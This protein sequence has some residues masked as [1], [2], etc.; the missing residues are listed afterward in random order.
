[1][2]SK[3]VGMAYDGKEYEEVKC[4]TACEGE[5]PTCGPRISDDGPLHEFQGSD[6]I[7]GSE[8]GAEGSTG[9]P[10]LVAD[11]DTNQVPMGCDGA[12]IATSLF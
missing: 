7:R 5:G 8:A 12:L 2:C 3:E 10:P 6:V 4:V 9:G 11:S 1:M